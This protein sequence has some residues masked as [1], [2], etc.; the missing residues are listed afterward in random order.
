MERRS[1]EDPCGGGAARARGLRGERR[2]GRGALPQRDLAGRSRCGQAVTLRGGA[3]TTGQARG[4][5]RDRRDV[6]MRS[7]AR[8]LGPASAILALQRS[9][10]NR[11][12]TRTLSTAAK[13]QLAR[14]PVK[15]QLEGDDDNRLEID[16]GIYFDQGGTPKNIGG[17]PW[18]DAWADFE[19]SGRGPLTARV[20]IKAGTKGR[21]TFYAD[22]M[23]YIAGD[24]D[25]P[26]HVAVIWEV[27]ADPY[28]ALTFT[29]VGRPQVH[30]DVRGRTRLGL[31]QVTAG[32]DEK[33]AKIQVGLDFAGATIS[34]TESTLKKGRTIGTPTVKLGDE[35]GSIEIPSIPDLAGERQDDQ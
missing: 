11:A 5:A 14:K 32:V 22:N 7:A 27:T 13:R 25:S 35:E 31:T 29:R 4:E 18:H 33:A 15:L 3:L 30:T 23:L 17:F 21:L 6:A 24:D 28:G 12:V 20:L 10:G 16:S 19:E 26:S 9:I 2:P 8:P 1:S 34:D